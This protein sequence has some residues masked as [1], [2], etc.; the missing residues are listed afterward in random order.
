MKN[1]KTKEE[2]EI[3]LNNLSSYDQNNQINCLNGD[4]S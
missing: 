4:I 2:D 3:F 1:K